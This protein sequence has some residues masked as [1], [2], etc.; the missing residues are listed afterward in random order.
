MK[1]E[2]SDPEHFAALLAGAEAEA[3][4]RRAMFEGLAQIIPVV[5]E[6]EVGVEAA[7]SKEAAE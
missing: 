5:V 4:R 3:H 6:K 7:T 2:R 1:L